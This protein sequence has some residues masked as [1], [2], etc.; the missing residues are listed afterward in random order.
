MLINELFVIMCD[1]NWKCELISTNIEFCLIEQLINARSKTWKK[2][3]INCKYLKEEK[4]RTNW[5]HRY[6]LAMDGWKL[7]LSTMLVLA[8][9]LEVIHLWNCERH[10]WRIYRGSSRADYYP[11]GYSRGRPFFY[12]DGGFVWEPF[13]PAPLFGPLFWCFPTCPEASN[14]LWLMEWDARM[15]CIL[16]VQR[17]FIDRVSAKNFTLLFYDFLTMILQ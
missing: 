3:G 2:N 8:C 6:K 9:I 15:F 10:R 1:V 12:G 7:L 17:N 11:H 13:A 5:G 16:F 4:L 14:L